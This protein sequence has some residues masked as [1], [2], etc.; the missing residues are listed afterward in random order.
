VCPGIKAIQELRSPLPEE[1]HFAILKIS[2][3][4]PK[5]HRKIIPK[6]AGIKKAAGLGF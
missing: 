5:F 4:K 3:I 6:A 1:D 2:A